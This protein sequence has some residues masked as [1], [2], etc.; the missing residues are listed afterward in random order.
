MSQWLLAGTG[1]VASLIL[2]TPARAQSSDHLLELLT[3]K[4][5]LTT[6][7]AEDLKAEATQTNAVKSAASKWKLSDAIKDIGLFGDMRFRYEYRSVETVGGQDGYRERFRYALRLG[8]RG[9][10]LDHFYYGLRLETAA[11]PR[12]PWV[13]FGDES[14]FPFPGPSSKSSD[15]VN[16][17]QVYLGWRPADWVELTVGKMP[18]PL[19]TTTM[20]WDGDI[21]P[22]GAAEKFKWTLG[23]VDLFATFGQF[24][25][26]DANPD[27]AITPF[28]GT[29][30]HQ[31]DAFLLAWQVGANVKLGPDMSVKAAPTLYNYTGRGSSAGFNT[32]FV[33]SAYA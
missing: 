1:A 5:I 14:A 21:N 31:S 19:Y 16:I 3:K 27:K 9:D 26:Q 29:V 25:Y 11:N 6:K 28:F 30:A 2:A 18:N 12:S 10:L 22:E 24:L 32:Y 33:G 8:L 17:G 23:K 7:E 4:G 15:G 13:T 20:I